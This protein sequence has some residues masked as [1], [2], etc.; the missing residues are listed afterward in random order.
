[1]NRLLSLL[2][3]FVFL[4][5]ETFAMRGGPTRR[6]VA[7]LSGTYSVILTQTSEDTDFF[8]GVGLGYIGTSIALVLVDAPGIGPASGHFLLFSSSAGISY[9]GT[10][11]GL[12]DTK[13][14]LHAVMGASQIDNSGVNQT[15]NGTFSASVVPQASSNST[16]QE[17][18]GTATTVSTATTITINPNGS[19]TIVSFTSFPV[20]YSLSGYRQSSSTGFGTVF[21][22]N[23]SGTGG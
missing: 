20:T 11:D 1:M 15:V 7:Q 22:Q 17:V 8:T 3:C 10:L 23:V 5:A 4:H 9:Q 21:S 16:L 6:G 19:R 18:T 13:G 12:S 14:F 2:M